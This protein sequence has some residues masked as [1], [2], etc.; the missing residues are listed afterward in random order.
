MTRENET[1]RRMPPTKPTPAMLAAAREEEDGW[2]KMPYPE[3]RYA[4]LW[5]AMLTAWK[6]ERA[7]GR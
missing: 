2:R 5:E 6:E 7:N 3:Q 1:T 4:F